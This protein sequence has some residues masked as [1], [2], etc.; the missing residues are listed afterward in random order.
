M[1]M[2]EPLKWFHLIRKFQGKREYGFLERVLPVSCIQRI[3][4]VSICLECFKDYS[5]GH[6]NSVFTAPLRLKRVSQV[7]P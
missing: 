4:A 7:M 5:K 6:T 2:A 3:D 1:Y